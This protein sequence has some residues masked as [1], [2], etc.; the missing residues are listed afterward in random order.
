MKSGSWAS[1]QAALPPEARAGGEPD[2]APEPADVEL[3]TAPCPV[4]GTP[5]TFPADSHDERDGYCS[6][7]CFERM[8]ADRRAD[9]GRAWRAANGG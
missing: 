2:D 8:D 4:C 9:Y 6:G 1:F 3:V 5:T 7:A